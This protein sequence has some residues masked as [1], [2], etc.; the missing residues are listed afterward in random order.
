MSLWLLVCLLVPALA[1]AYLWVT[2]RR[3]HNRAYIERVST[4]GFLAPPPTVQGLRSL[5][6]LARFL[7]F[8][9]VG[10]IKVL[11]RENLDNV[12]GPML[13]APNHPNSADVAVMPLVLDRPARYMAARGVF[14]FAGGWGALLCAPMGAFAVDLSPGMGGPA[15]DAA[16]KVLTSGE[17][18]CM[19]PEGWA[20]LNGRLGPLK[21]GAVR[22]T[23][24]AAQLLGE[25]TY[26]VPVFL[27][28]GRY[29]GDWIRKFP[30]P[31]EYTFV[32]LNSWLY[33]R[34]VTVVIGKPIPSTELPPDDTRATALL[35]DRIV[36]LDPLQR[37][38]EP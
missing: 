27:R 12:K 2:P 31:I 14:T 29:P 23:R 21:K 25:T 34:G 22:I 16:V 24:E 11:G 30:P 9:Q 32:L 33:R 7:T 6:R 13:V 4:C 15:K 18:L 20:Y 36:A 8:V 37:N 19:F 26:L 28:Y 1:F 17:T 5:R 10:R 35:R 3:A 38:G